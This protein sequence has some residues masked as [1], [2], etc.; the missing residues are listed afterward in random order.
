M[1]SNLENLL[2]AQNPEVY[3]VLVQIGLGVAVG[4][5]CAGFNLVCPKKGHLE[6]IAFYVGNIALPMVVF[7]D[8]AT[9]AVA[10]I[11]MSVIVACAAG[12]IAAALLI[13]PA[14]YLWYNPEA[15]RSERFKAAALFAYFVTAS[16]DFLIGFPLLNAV[17][18]GTTGKGFDATAYT[19]VNA[20]VNC[21]VF[22]PIGVILVEIGASLQHS[23]DA[24]RRRDAIWKVLVSIL[25]NPLIAAAFIG[26]AYN[27]GINRGQQKPL[28]GLLADC[29]NLLAGPF[30]MMALFL[31]GAS[32]GSFKLSVWSTAL[33]AAK[34]GVCAVTSF[35]LVSYMLPSNG[36]EQGMQ[37]ELAKFTFFYGALPS[38]SAPLI[39]AMV[40]RVPAATKQILAT[41]I[42]MC[43]VASFPSV[44]VGSVTIAPG[45]LAQ[46]VD[47]C[48]IG[49]MWVSMFCAAG[50]VALMV[51]LGVSRLRG[52]VGMSS[53]PHWENKETWLLTGL[54]LYGCCICLY[55]ALSL[56]LK[57][58]CPQSVLVSW[59][60]RA[61]AVVQN[62]C[63]GAPPIFL[64][65]SGLHRRPQVGVRWLV[66]ILAVSALVAASLLVQPFL[67]SSLCNTK[68]DDMYLPAM[69]AWVIALLVAYCVAIYIMKRQERERYSALD[70]ISQARDNAAFTMQ[71]VILGVMSYGCVLLAVQAVNVTCQLVR[72]SVL[73]EAM[74]L[75][76]C[77]DPG[78]GVFLF[79][80]VLR[81]TDVRAMC[82]RRRSKSGAFML[83]LRAMLLDDQRSNSSSGSGDG[84]PPAWVS[85]LG[86][87]RYSD[88]ALLRAEGPD[89]EVHS[90][91]EYEVVRPSQCGRSATAG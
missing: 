39:L 76:M 87:D 49:S 38:S 26:L 71:D 47:L 18:G 86:A 30:E 63:R 41:G 75:E 80:M 22:L 82:Q 34:V 3:E 45:D 44:L 81:L 2:A 54:G 67:L 17:F 27:A 25:R 43:L 72:H 90:D 23:A 68:L 42:L 53:S 9:T 13:W 31:T 46:V 1:A 21:W 20:L 64:V 35:A 85:R 65:L 8:S 66:G 89:M 33:A 12:K 91:T 19:T 55:T 56:D 50:A 14:A 62:L 88:S 28:P 60:D 6:G 52:I 84:P 51:W 24:G 40:A 16:N 7:K 4:W 15:E 48:H 78:Q 5:V 70:V 37:K 73:T 79:V 29:V 61:F 74:I 11:Q 83:G 10:S 69:A 58:S 59:Q 32:L 36:L 57:G 77:L